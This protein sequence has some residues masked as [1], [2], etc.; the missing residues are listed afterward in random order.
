MRKKGSLLKRMYLTSA[1][2]ELRVARDSWGLLSVATITYLQVFAIPAS[3][4]LIITGTIVY[5]NSLLIAACILSGKGL[6]DEEIQQNANELK[7]L[8]QPKDDNFN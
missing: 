8:N 1:P 2:L 7:E 4:M 6:S 5:I 3:V